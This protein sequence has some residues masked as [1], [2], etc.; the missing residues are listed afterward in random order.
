MSTT[1]LKQETQQFDTLKALLDSK[2]REAGIKI[3]KTKPGDGKY[4]AV[5]SSKKVR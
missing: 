3:N 4:S 5:L 1:P 2:L